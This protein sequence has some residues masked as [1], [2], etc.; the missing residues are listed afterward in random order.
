M[1]KLSEYHI[2]PSNPRLIKDERFKKLVKSIDEFPK[3]MSLRPIIID[4]YGMILGGNMRFKALKELGYKEVPD[5]WIKKA[6][7]LTEDEVRRFI[8]EDNVPF[9]EW[10]WDRLANEWDEQE[11]IEW[12]L[13]IPD[14]AHDKEEVEDDNFEIPETIETD[15][16]AG[17]LFEIGPHRLLCGDSTKPEDVARLMGDKKADM[18]FTDPPYNVN[19]GAVLNHPSW[20]RTKD[21][22]GNP[23]SRKAGNDQIKNDNLSDEEWT[24]F[25]KNYMQNILKYCNGAIYICMSNK[26]MYSNQRIFIDQGGQ[27]SSFI[28][29]K[30]DS[31]VL[32]MQDYQRQY[33]PILYGWKKGAKRFWCGDRNQSDIWEVKRPKS[34]P[35]HPT[36]KPIELCGRAINNSS[37]NNNIIQDL[38]GGS[39]STMVAAQQL[40]RICYMN[41]LDPKYCQVIIDR[42]RR[43]NP[44]IE[45]KKNGEVYDEK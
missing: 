20:K 1:K 12:G 13:E 45:V 26:E 14:F 10:D 33:E 9:G 36:M 41:E 18:V 2:N 3:M 8:V 38:F 24:L 39:G 40:G 21:K 28:I 25:V 31:F 6:E 23:A 11:L 16:K 29:W 22:N 37:G 34:S 30:K 27:W 42:M 5:E 43:L 7:D 17:D 35:E 15:I 4:N 32:G 19:Y 44:E